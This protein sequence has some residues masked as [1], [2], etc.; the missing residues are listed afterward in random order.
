M[1]PFQGI[2]FIAHKCEINL[3][4]VPALT[5]IKREIIY[6]AEIRTEEKSYQQ[7]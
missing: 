6:Q 4:E 7:Q 5:I 1:M 3:I 2:H